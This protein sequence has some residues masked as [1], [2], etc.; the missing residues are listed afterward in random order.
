MSRNFELLTEIEHELNQTNGR[1]LSTA[2][3]QVTKPIVS[4]ERQRYHVNDDGMQQLI[5]RVFLPS[6]A[7]A[8]HSVVFCGI[9]ANNGS[10]PVC[11]RAA[12]TLA[13]NTGQSVCLIDADLRSSRLLQMLEV[14][15]GC[16]DVNPSLSIRERCKKIEEN[17]WFAGPSILAETPATLPPIEELKD[18]LGQ[19][20]RTFE[21]LLIDAPAPNICGDTFL[22]GQAADAAV[23]VIDANVTRRLTAR[24]TIETLDAV[25]VRLVGTVLYDRTY[26]IPERIYRSL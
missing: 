17:L 4:F 20:C 23:L 25:G 1:H 26:P 16:R 7:T 21:Y 14:D 19:L 24:K 15:P 11:E 5:Q 3:P 12:R 2:P 18:L 8:P 6:D 22:L 13:A 10:T 9:G